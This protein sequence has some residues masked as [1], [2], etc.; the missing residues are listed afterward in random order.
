MKNRFFTFVPQ[1]LLLLLLT[2]AFMACQD[3][4]EPIYEGYGLV[5]KTSDN[6]FS[7][8]LDDGYQVYPL[9]SSIPPSRLNDS[10]R[11]YL[12]FNILEENDSTASV[13]I[14]Y[15]DTI[16]TKSIL[17]YD[18]TIS[19]S[20]GQAPVKINKA[21]FAHGFLN[22]EFM[23]AGRINV[24][25]G[26]AHMVNLL[27]CPATDNQLNFEF[28]HNDFGDYREKIYMGIVSFPIQELIAELER[29]IKMN[30][31]FNDSENTTRSIT[32]TYK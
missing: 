2:F 6:K 29:P 3:E 4:C 12:Q 15:A 17:P 1:K 25:Q 16:L 27:Q 9:E 13:R 26:H 20:V 18:E 24:N 14:T 10:T 23:F 32:L 19:D 7:V 11:L 22:F 28:R 30:I 21:W 8:I 5:S 31:K